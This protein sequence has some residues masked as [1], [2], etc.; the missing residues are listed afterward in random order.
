MSPLRLAEMVRVAS[1]KRRR[2]VAEIR[3]WVL[4]G[5]PFGI[6]GTNWNWRGV[7]VG[8]AL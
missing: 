4:P 6:S 8:R 1:I 3:F 2:D 7:F 5:D